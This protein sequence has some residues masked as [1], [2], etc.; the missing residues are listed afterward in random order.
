[1]S[2]QEQAVGSLWDMEAGAQARELSAFEKMGANLTAWKVLKFL[3]GA[4]S[5]ALA[6]GWSRYVNVGYVFLPAFPDYLDVTLG[7]AI[8]LF[9]FFDYFRDIFRK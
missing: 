5:I 2:K 6:L 4:A 8:G 1:L 7:V 9:L 3:F